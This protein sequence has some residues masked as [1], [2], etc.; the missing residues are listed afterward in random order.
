MK[1]KNLWGGV[2]SSKSS[3][4]FIAFN[5]SLGFDKRLY[6]HDIT[7]SL[8]YAKALYKANV[9]DH[10]EL[11]E[12]AKGLKSVLADLENDPSI[13]Q[14]HIDAGTEDI[15]SMVGLLLTE[16]IGVTAKKLHT[17]RSR[18]DQVVTDLKL[19]MIEAVKK[20]CHT[21]DLT[22]KA[23]D[24]N[25]E[26]YG[27]SPLP[28]YT[29]LQKAQPIKWALL[30]ESYMTKLDRDKKKFENCLETLKIMP[31]GSGALAGNPWKID[32]ED[33]AKDLGF[34]QITKNS[35]DA[36]SDRDFVL[37]FLYCCSTVMVHLS[38]ISEDLIIY[39][40]SEFSF[41]NLSDKVTSGSSL[42]PQKKNPD[43]LELIR[44]KS[45]RVFAHL[46]SLLTTLKGLPSTYNKDL[47]ED[48]EALF[49][50][51][52]TVIPCLK[53]MALVFQGLKLNTKVCEQASSTGYINATIFADSLVTL[54]HPFREAHELTGRAV[55]MGISLGKE[56]H[57]LSADELRSIAPGLEHIT[58]Q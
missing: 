47:Q 22:I 17:G 39:A 9:I 18:N 37:D 1:Q 40:T 2:F 38:K 6:K 20:V 23:I 7:G 45:G 31:L 35:L 5:Q 50:A 27:T 29:H 49:G 53:V 25:I 14:M 16:K 41:I 34:K 55:K 13:F 36:V 44:G 24:Q 30:L 46:Q 51:Y 54:G 3:S 42:M 58:L 43:A 28:G 52:D 48:K 15:H 11:E 8:A 4:E 32:R 12:L 19:W 26:K 57:E 21:I 33:L 10:S 56:L